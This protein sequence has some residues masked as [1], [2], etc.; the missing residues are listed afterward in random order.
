[1]DVS[2]EVCVDIAASALFRINHVMGFVSVI[3]SVSLLHKGFGCLKLAFTVNQF[4]LSLLIVVVSSICLSTHQ[5]Q[6]WQK[7][8]YPIGPDLGF[9]SHL[10]IGCMP[11]SFRFMSTLTPFNV[12]LMSI[13]TTFISNGL[14]RVISPSVNE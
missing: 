12:C 10:S 8:I 2:S 3:S 11:V 5:N 1:M 6:I 7:G 9:I 13:V 14:Q 4:A